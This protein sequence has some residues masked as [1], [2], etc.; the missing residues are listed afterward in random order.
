MRAVTARMRGR[1]SASRPAPCGVTLPGLREPAL[2]GSWRLHGLAP[3]LGQA[4]PTERP[5]LMN[6]RHRP[7]EPSRAV[8]LG[9]L[10]FDP[11]V[12]PE[13]LVVDA[14]YPP[15]Q[16]IGRCDRLGHVHAGREGLMLER[17][18]DRE[19]VQIRGRKVPLD[20]IAAGWGVESPG[21][22]VA[23]PD[24]DEVAVWRA[25]IECERDSFCT[26]HDSNG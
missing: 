26:R 25:Q 14:G 11:S 8:G 22:R 21:V 1:L 17:H 5:Q 7:P 16:G 4:G 3:P 9:R 2:P 6:L 18:R 20:E 12:D 10:V 24:M 15:E 19:L 13:Q 23:A